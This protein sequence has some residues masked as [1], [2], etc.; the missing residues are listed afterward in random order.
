MARILC[1]NQW[2][3]SKR[4]KNLPLNQWFRSKRPKNLPLTWGNEP[5]PEPGYWDGENPM[6][7]PM[8]WWQATQKSGTPMGDRGGHRGEQFLDFSVRVAPR[9]PCAVI[10][11]Y[12]LTL[13]ETYQHSL[14]GNK[15]YSSLLVEVIW[16][17]CLIFES[18][19]LHIRKILT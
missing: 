7:K 16:V 15:Q 10:F 5:G 8:V 14:L 6:E 9:P 17:C 11:C 19:K 12:L 2:F 18:M 13:L 1:K 3:R 4:P